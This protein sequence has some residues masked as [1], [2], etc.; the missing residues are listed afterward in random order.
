MDNAVDLGAESM[1]WQQLEKS[2]EAAGERS[3]FEIKTLS[4]DPS[5]HSF[6]LVGSIRTEGQ[7]NRRGVVHSKKF[8]VHP[9]KNS[10]KFEKKIRKIQG[11]F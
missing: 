11:F 9:N 3:L 10:K 8:L 1:V 5:H 4:I 7:A 2:I 6:K